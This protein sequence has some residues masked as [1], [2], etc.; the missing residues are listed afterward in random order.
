MVSENVRDVLRSEAGVAVEDND[1]AFSSQS[2][3]GTVRLEPAH[4]GE[5]L[6]I[7]GLCLAGS[8]EENVGNADNNVV[9]DSASSDKIAEPSERLRRPISKG[10]K[11]Q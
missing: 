4:L 5:S 11:G 7:Y 9:D 10:N 6:A 3:P 8:V 2:N 1:E